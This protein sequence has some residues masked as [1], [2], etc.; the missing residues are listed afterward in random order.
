MPPN[1]PAFC[2]KPLAA[3]ALS[4]LLVSV[5]NAVRGQDMGKV[6]ETIT[7]LAAPDMHGRGYVEQG[8]KRA[9]TYLR[10]RF[11]ALKLHSFTRQ[12][13]QDF[14]I[15]VNTFPGAFSL[16]VDGRLLQPGT[17]FIADPA[18][19]AGRV[20]GPLL[21]LDTLIFTSEAAGQRFLTQSLSGQVVVLRQRDAD[22][23]RTLP[24]AFAAHLNQ[25]AAL[26]TLVPDKLTASLADT[27][28]AQPRLQVLAKRW[29]G[30]G[31]QAA[32]QLDA[33]LER[34]YPTQNLIGYVPGRVQPDSFLVV[35][36]HYDHLGR[37]GKK[38]FF[39]GAND[40]ASGTAMLLT[41][42]EYYAKPENQPAYSIAFMAFGAEE[43]GLLGSRHY[44]AHPLF[45]LSRIR[46][47]INMDLL[48]TGEEG[49]TVVNGK[50]FERQFQ[51]LTQLNATGRFVPQLAARGRAA[52]SDHFPFAEQGVPTFF[53]YTRGGIKAYHDIYDRPD[54]LPLTG[55]LGIFKLTTRFLNLLGGQA[56]AAQP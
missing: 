53:F 36:A 8:S 37:M 22:R 11:R 32:V 23:L 52:N 19:G 17:D 43:A 45:P 20:A 44:V 7:I 31:Q 16:G 47:L 55:F 48:G 26:I 6:R 24:D 5:G 21:P 30:R 29:S 42:A 33:R 28:H 27:Q 54:T 9:A 40:N 51:Q 38:T 15:T 10:R 1:L 50:L 4:L 14:T 25:A 2:P 41:L 12:Y 46:F 13:A 35:T 49:I 18:S 34:Q 3:L 56:G 39:P